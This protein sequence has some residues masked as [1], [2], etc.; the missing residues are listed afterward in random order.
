[1]IDHLITVYL[2]ISGAGWSSENLTFGSGG[3]LLQRLDR[4]TQRCAYKCSQA[5]VGGEEREVYKDPVTDPGKRSKRGRLVLVRDSDTGAVVTVREEERGERE[6]LMVTVF[7]N[8]ELVRDWT[9]EEVK[10]RALV[11]A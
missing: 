5:V 2:Y 7:E 4:D 1:M 11:A 9:W 8:G 10:T 6:D 3:A